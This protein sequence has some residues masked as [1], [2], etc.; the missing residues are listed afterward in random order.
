[1]ARQAGSLLRA[2]ALSLRRQGNRQSTRT[3]GD[4]G[5]GDSPMAKAPKQKTKLQLQ[6]SGP[7]G[8]RSNSGEGPARGS[9]LQASL[10]RRP[11]PPQ[12]GTRAVEGKG[13]G[14]NLAA[15]RRTLAAAFDPGEVY[16][17][18]E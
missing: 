3:I 15:I 4:R 11:S 9:P 18:H 5:P 13:P 10:G 1:M 17:Y 16:S 12:T 6:R 8:L 2:G 7:E 14:A